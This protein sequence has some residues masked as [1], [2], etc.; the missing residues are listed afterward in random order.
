MAAT[1]FYEKSPS[2]LS[3]KEGEIPPSSSKRLTGMVMYTKFGQNWARTFREVEDM[4]FY[5][6]LHTCVAPKGPDPQFVQI[7]MPLS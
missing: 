6:F 2:F 3:W 5:M 7:S 4:S 1:N